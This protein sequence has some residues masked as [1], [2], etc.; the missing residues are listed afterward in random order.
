MNNIDRDQ[1][2]PTCHVTTTRLDDISDPI[3]Q[4]LKGFC[5]D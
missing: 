3:N 4:I 2:L 5:R 1:L